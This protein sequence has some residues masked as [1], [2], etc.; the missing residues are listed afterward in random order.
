MSDR[1]ENY[2]SLQR[3]LWVHD[4]CD[5]DEDDDSIRWMCCIKGCQHY[6]SKTQM[7]LDFTL[8]THMT[9]KNNNEQLH[10]ITV[11]ITRKSLQ[12][13]LQWKVRAKLAYESDLNVCV[14]SSKTVDDD[15]GNGKNVQTFIKSLDNDPQNIPDILILCSHKKRFNDL[16]ILLKNAMLRPRVINGVLNTFTYNFV[17]DE[18]DEKETLNNMTNFLEAVKDT[19]KS[20]IGFVLLVTGSPDSNMK[21][22]LEDKLGIIEMENIQ[23]HIELSVSHETAKANWTTILDH[24]LAEFNDGTHSP[25][26]YIQEVFKDPEIAPNMKDNKPKI[27][28]APGASNTKSHYEIARYFR[29]RHNCWSLIHNG[30]FKGFV[31]NYNKRQLTFDEFNDMYDVS[32]PLL[33]AQGRVELRETLSRWREVYPTAHLVIT[34]YNTLKRAITFNTTGFNFTHMIVSSYHAKYLNELVQLYGRGQGKK[35]YCRPMIVISPK[36]VYQRACDYIEALS[37]QTDID[38]DVISM[39]EL[40]SCTNKS[41]SDKESTET[42]QKRKNKSREN[43][44]YTYIRFKSQNHLENKFFRNCV[45]DYVD[46]SE[47]KVKR[48]P[49]KIKQNEK[50]FKDGKWLTSVSALGFI[51]VTSEYIKSKFHLIARGCTYAGFI[52][53]YQTNQYLESELEFWMVIRDII[54]KTDRLEEFKQK[55][56]ERLIED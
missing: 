17:F 53:V 31:D 4:D 38:I 8:K 33:R 12:E 19:Y 22:Q 20:Y 23:P 15:S 54:I 37:Q 25:L 14:L 51:P 42:K 56:H 11:F 24:E 35:Q 6:M 18:A 55:Y 9:F 10:N 7:A 1:F 39:T 27:I 5:D 34:G 50:H 26:Q 45:L 28:F 30:K 40:L 43:E 49:N 52:P 2:T 47:Y 32:T 41:K 16:E 48:G 3:K 46:T 29:E 21:Q 36:Q 13:A 44:T